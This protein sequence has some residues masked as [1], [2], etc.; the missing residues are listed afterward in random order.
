MKPH[1]RV[2]T[3]PVPTYLSARHKNAG[4][5]V[6]HGACRHKTLLLIEIVNPIRAGAAIVSALSQPSG[7]RRHLPAGRGTQ[8]H[9]DHPGKYY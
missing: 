3:V 7:E 4:L 9:E 2:P 8:L 6:A 1:G 5:D